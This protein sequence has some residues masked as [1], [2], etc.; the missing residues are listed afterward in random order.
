[1]AAFG[2]KAL[3]AMS[4]ALN[5]KLP[6]NFE[7]INEIKLDQLTIII[8]DSHGDTSHVLNTVKNLIFDY[9]VPLIIGDI[10]NDAS[11]LA[12][13]LCEQQQVSLISFSR[14]PLVANLGEYIFVFN[15]SYNQHIDFLVKYAREHKK[16]ERFAILYPRHNYGIAM[17]KAFY[18]AIIK[19]GGKITALEAYDTHETTFTKIAGELAGLHC[20]KPPCDPKKLVPNVDF[21]ALFIPDFTALA[22]LIPALV[23]ADILITNNAQAQK[24]YASS[25]KIAHPQP[26]QILGPSS[27]NDDATL[28]KIGKQANGAYFVDTLSFDQSPNLAEFKNSYD[29]LNLGAPSI[30]EA[31]AYEAIKV[32]QKILATEHKSKEDLQKALRNY[33]SQGA[34]LSKIKFNNQ[35]ELNTSPTGFTLEDGKKKVL[36]EEALD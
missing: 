18:N 10:T 7:A 27:W 26:V 2:K 5:I 14:H 6:D 33:N 19:S 16:Y 32:A 28:Q 13:Q 35:G 36:G 15:Q 25:I 21:E 22:Y 1:L 31:L 4:M 11:L 29:Q 12:A 8:A 30:T 34:L 23:Q 24:T 17:A 9:H 3:G 20:V